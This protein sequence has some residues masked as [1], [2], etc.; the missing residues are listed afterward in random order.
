MDSDFKTVR[1]DRSLIALQQ[2]PTQEDTFVCCC[3]AKETCEGTAREFIASLLDRF[4]LYSGELTV[5]SASQLTAALQHLFVI[6]K[7]FPGF[8]VS[9][10][11]YAPVD[12]LSFLQLWGLFTGLQRKLSISDFVI[13]FKD[14]LV[15]SSLAPSETLRLPLPTTHS[16]SLP[17]QVISCEDIYCWEGGWRKKFLVTAALAHFRFL[18][19]SAEQLAPSAIE[20]H[21]RPIFGTSEIARSHERLD[22][23]LKAVRMEEDQRRFIYANRSNCARRVSATPKRRNFQ[24]VEEDAQAFASI[25]DK[26]NQSEF[27]EILLNSQ[28]RWLCGKKVL[29]RECYLIVD[30]KVTLGDCRSEI[31]T[32]AKESLGGVFM[33]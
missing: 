12:R 30:K 9:G 10:L 31:E 33:G 8:S 4:H 21:L 25:K 3:F 19:L 5:S 20:E 18:F 23:Q 22:S 16:D 11:E 32:F 27:S 28:G 13:F 14:Q 17:P 1:L 24:V 26:I 6:E 15:L 2:V 7:K 29:D